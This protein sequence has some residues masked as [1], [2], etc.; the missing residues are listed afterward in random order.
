MQVDC[1]T[2]F[3]GHVEDAA[4]GDPIVGASIALSTGQF[5]TTDMNGDFTI[6]SVPAYD[7]AALAAD[8]LNCSAADLG[9]EIVVPPSYGSLTTGPLTVPA[10]SIMTGMTTTLADVTFTVPTTGT[11][12]GLITGDLNPGELV[13]ITD[14]QQATSTVA[15]QANGSFVQSGLAAG[16]YSASYLF[17]GSP[18]PTSVPFSI[19]ANSITAINIQFVRGQGAE[20]IS[21]LVLMDDDNEATPMTPAD[22]AQVLLVGTDEGSSGGLLAA[23]DSNG[24]AEFADVTGPFTVTVVKD[25]FDQ[26][27]SIRFATSLIDINPSGSTIGVFI[28][29]ENDNGFFVLDATLSGTVS[30]M[31]TLAGTESL[32]VFVEE[33]NF[34]GDSGFSSSA[35]VNPSDGTYSL[36][37]PSGIDFDLNLVHADFQ[38]ASSPIIAS[39]VLGGVSGTTPA[40][41]VVQ[42]WDF[43]SSALI[44]WDQPTPVSFSNLDASLTD[45]DVCAD[46]FS[47]SGGVLYFYP[48]YSGPAASLT[49]INLPD[50][51]DPNLAGLDIGIFA[52]TQEGKS[53][54][55][56]QECEFFPSTQPTSLAFDFITLPAPIAPADQAAYTLAEWEALTVNYTEGTSA[57]GSNGLNW[58]A[59]EGDSFAGQEGGI[60]ATCW[61]ILVP[62]GTTSFALPRS[63]LPLF[64]EGDFIVAEFEQI[65][66]AGTTFSYNSFFDGTLEQNLTDLRANTTEECDSSFEIYFDLISLP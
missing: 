31:P 17:A 38:A 10:A 41:T 63:P 61:S 14:S 47:T 29:A 46:V 66:F 53:T 3:T 19:T 40:G 34:G 52:E 28:N 56:Y 65:R 54:M 2:V 39:M 18:T 13:V 30:N 62:A 43:G 8:P 1:A 5:G 12:A 37:I 25:V 6:N 32:E 44:A 7:A 24:I 64:S 21:V 23:T 20:D 16:D 4:S 57:Q 45:I 42:D 26:G 9:Y 11:L 50:L 60:E 22:M 49:S 59:F 15:V 51:T 35:T 48:I 33:T 36:S 27:D 58:Y 55:E